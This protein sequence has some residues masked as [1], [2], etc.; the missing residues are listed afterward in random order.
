MNAIHGCTLATPRYEAHV[1]ALA[2]SFLACHPGA[3]FSVLMIGYTPQ[4]LPDGEPFEVLVPADVGIDEQELN[5]RATMYTTQGLT[6]SLKP[7]LL[8][9]LL[10][11]GEG[12]AVIYIDADGCV[13][14][15]LAGLGE[16]ARRHSLL[17]S[18]H[19][20]D[21][22]PIPVVAAG[23]ELWRDDSPEQIIMRAGVMN[24]GLIGVGSGAEP[25]LEWWSSRVARRCVFDEARGLMLCQTWLTLATALFEHHV[26]RDRGC[27]V[28]GWN[29]QARDIGWTGDTP[30]IDGVPL[31]HFHFAGSFDPEQPH[32]MTPIAKHATWWASLEERPGTARVVREYAARLLAHGYRNAHATPPLYAAM[33]DGRS[34]EPWMR[35]SYRAALVEAEEEGS[36]E[37][38]NPFCD[39]AD[40]FLAWLERRTAGQLDRSGPSPPVQGRSSGKEMTAALLDRAGLLARIGELETIRDE[41]ISWAERASSELRDAQAAGIAADADRRELERVRATME[42][43][44]RSP[45]WRI[46]RPLRVVKAFVRRKRAPAGPA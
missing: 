32:L 6:S 4:T 41:A 36:E 3:R 5:R 2:E 1:R 23:R 31:R 22:Y 39:G 10:S 19:S 27:N 30:T 18:P 21:P 20:L 33:P 12:D 17:L 7:D 11:R 26:L 13:Y 14:D 44:W 28:A 25:F 29:L 34:L 38:P 37:P 35:T 9:T 15:D 43:V 16:L 8:A 42:S 40:R 46:T 45:S 24:G